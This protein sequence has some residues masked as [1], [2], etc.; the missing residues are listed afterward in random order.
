MI[1]IFKEAFRNVEVHIIYL[2][3]CA[4]MAYFRI[5]ERAE[6]VNSRKR[7]INYTTKYIRSLHEHYKQ[8]AKTL[9]KEENK[10]GDLDFIKSTSIISNDRSIDD[11]DGIPLDL[12]SFGLTETKE[13]F[14]NRFIKWFNDKF[15]SDEPP[16]FKTNYH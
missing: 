10:V 3:T 14:Q 12:S 1:N 16:K 9:K 5:N 7:E 15:N 8:M 11:L 13:D 4:E 6:Q 2:H